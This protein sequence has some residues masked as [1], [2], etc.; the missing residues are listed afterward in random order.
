MFRP[1][2]STAD[3]K[4]LEPEL[5]WHALDFQVTAA[6]LLYM[7]IEQASENIQSA[8]AAAVC[9]SALTALLQTKYTSR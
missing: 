4:D 3:K 1:S 9:W 7:W 5:K 8:A 6:H 2:N